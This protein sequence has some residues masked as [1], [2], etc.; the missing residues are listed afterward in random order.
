[1]QN[2]FSDFTDSL[3]KAGKEIASCVKGIAVKT[4][5]S[6]PVVEEVAGT[7][8]A[9][10]SGFATNTNAIPMLLKTSSHCEAAE[11]NE[12]ALGLIYF[13]KP[14]FLIRPP[15]SLQ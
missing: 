13:R 1:M 4:S 8:L 5:D 11:L 2:Q 12:H 3:D 10:L 14:N 9:L 6:T 15:K 7:S